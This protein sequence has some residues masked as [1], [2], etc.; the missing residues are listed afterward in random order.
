MP[1]PLWKII[2]RGVWLDEPCFS[3]AKSD[4]TAGHVILGAKTGEPSFL[5]ASSYEPGWPGWLGYRDEI[6]VCSYGDF[7]PA[8]RDE[9]FEKSGDATIQAWNLTNKPGENFSIFFV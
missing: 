4:R 9:K 6:G 3:L 8:F 7:Q 2:V 1:L 5:R